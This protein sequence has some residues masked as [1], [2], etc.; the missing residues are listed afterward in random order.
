MDNSS[1]CCGLRG[2]KLKLAAPFV[3][4][5]GRLVIGVDGAGFLEKGDEIEKGV[6]GNIASS[7]FMPAMFVVICP[8]GR[9]LCIHERW[10]GGRVRETA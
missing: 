4:W 1:E 8:V 2:R 10:V 7:A 5:V 6:G 9:V 3:L